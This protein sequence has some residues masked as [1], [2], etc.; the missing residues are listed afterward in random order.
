M[1]QDIILVTIDCWRYDAVQRMRNLLSLTDRY[2]RTEAICQSAA[3][4]G[5]FPAI[6]SS[7]YYPYA[8]KG[9]IYPTLKCSGRLRSDIHPLPQ[10]LSENGYSTGAVIASNPWLNKWANYFDYFWNDGLSGVSTDVVRFGSPLLREIKR[11]YRFILLRNWVTASELARRAKDWYVKQ[12]QPRFLWMHLMEPHLPFFPGLKKGLAEGFLKSHRVNVQFARNPGNCSK[13]VL[14]TIQNLYWKSIEKLDEQISEI[15]EFFDEDA[16]VLIM[17]DHGEEFFHGVYGHARLYD[18]CVRVP[19]LIKWTLPNSLELPKKA[20]RQ[21]D[22]PPTVLQGLKLPIPNNW[23]GRV[24]QEKPFLPSPMINHAP[25]LERT[26]IGIRTEGRKLI[27]T[28]DSTN[29][30]EIGRELY[31]LEEDREEK[32]DIYNNVDAEDL[33]KYLEEFLQPLK[34]S[35]SERER[36]RKLGERLRKQGV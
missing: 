11:V 24:I 28:F 36:L 21:I 15:F 27:R 16:T 33:A 34:F 4:N 1:S 8:Y 12:K 32:N 13:E 14:H 7:M 17:A 35:S 22:L 26:Y 3:T 23:Q 31:N 25:R 6:L 5:V 30:E 2:V 9:C 29:G 10:V 18:E 20:L 19:L